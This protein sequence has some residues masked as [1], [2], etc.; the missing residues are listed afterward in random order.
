MAEGAA[1]TNPTGFIST[2]TRLIEVIKSS[3]L[4][5][6]LL[7]SVVGYG[8]ESENTF[9]D[10]PLLIIP[11]VFLVDILYL[12]L[13]FVTMFE[14]QI[15]DFLDLLFRMKRIEINGMSIHNSEIPGIEL[16]P[17]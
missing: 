8:I 17:V 3:G 11:L 16:L 7:L 13:V 6:G 15:K 2:S 5:A 14:L 10:K 9:K 1:A 4:C 12:A